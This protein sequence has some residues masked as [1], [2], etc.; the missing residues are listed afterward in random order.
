MENWN[1]QIG[2]SLLLVGIALIWAVRRTIRFFLASHSQGCH[3]GEG[4]GGCPTGE[5][6]ATQ[7]G[8]VDLKS[9]SNHTT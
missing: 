8:F 9:I 4:C 3:A 1:W 7:K 5:T 2:V 6:N